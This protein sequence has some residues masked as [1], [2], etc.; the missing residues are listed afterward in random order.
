LALDPA[1]EIV[2]SANGRNHRVRIASI[3][4]AGARNLEAVATD[5]SIY[6]SISGPSRALG[7]I[8]SVAYTGRA[9]V[10]FMD[11]PL[12]TGNEIAWAPTAAAFASPWPGQVVILKSATESNYTLDT[13]LTRAAI[14]GVTTADFYSGPTSRWDQ[15]N[16]LR[17][18]LFNGALSSKDDLTVLGGANALAL[19]NQDGEWEILQFANADLTA[20]KQWSLTKLLRGQAGT[21][22][23][24]R[25]PVPAGARVV[26]L[27]G[28]QKQLALTLDQYNLPFN[29]LWGPQGKPI[30]DPAFQGATKQFAGAGLRPYAPC[31]LR[32][33]YSGDDIALSWIRRD[34]SPGSDGWEQTEIPMSESSERYDVEILDA[35]GDVV[36]TVS[37]IATPALTYTASDIATDFPGGLPSPFRF[38]VYQLSTTVGRGSRATAA[39][40]I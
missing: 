34:R 23:A 7:A 29:Y 36:R 30:S 25:N 20:P 3:D 18:R 13:A 12:L 19:E 15:T 32:A 26:V 38:N 4:D 6:E 31:Q 22:S 1:D 11:L 24:M 5:P 9:V 33:A 35:A 8:Q 16:T 27:D 14:I 40:F 2:L 28:A 10:A 21:E 37:A 39:I 17:I